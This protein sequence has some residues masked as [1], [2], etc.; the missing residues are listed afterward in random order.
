MT[1]EVQLFERTLLRLGQ[2][3]IRRVLLPTDLSERSWQALGIAVEVAASAGAEL[4]LVHVVQP[5]IGASDL[6]GFPSDEEVRGRTWSSSPDSL[7]TLAKQH[8]AELRVERVE[9]ESHDISKAIDAYAVEREIDLIVLATA[10]RHGA[11]RWFMGS[12]A[13][14]LVV[15][16]PCPVLTLA[17]DAPEHFAPPSPTILAPV[18]FSE[19]SLE[20]LALASSLCSQLGGSLILLHV[21]SQRPL[22]AAYGDFAMA[23]WSASDV[24][25]QVKS[26]LEELAEMIPPEVPTH[27]LVRSGMTATEI[28]ETARARDADLI[29]IGSHGLSGFARRV[30][31]SVTQ[32]VLRLAPMPVLICKPGDITN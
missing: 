27:C 26:S 28:V 24:T 10:A 4:H 23:S 7:R 9:V 13:E 8:L 11:S 3:P 14:Q 5:G 29:L 12:I 31:G 15:T 32:R 1:K 6:D 2:R 16:A 21:I 25:P 17:A 20:S 19:T 22:P 30:L 18:D